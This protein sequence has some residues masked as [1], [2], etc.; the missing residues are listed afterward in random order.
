MNCICF[1][2]LFSLFLIVWGGFLIGMGA[3]FGWWGCSFLIGK[4]GELAAES[5]C[6]GLLGAGEGVGAVG[7]GEVHLLLVVVEG[8]AGGG[9]GGGVVVDALEGEGA[10]A[11]A[12]VGVGG[13]GV[14]PS[15]APGGGVA[16]VAVGDGE[17]AAV[18]EGEGAGDVTACA[19]G[20]V[21]A[22]VGAVDPAGGVFFFGAGGQ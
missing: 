5:G 11:V 19:F 21:V 14:F 4:G 1:V 16:V 7:G 6:K 9:V 15:V 10:G 18:F 3:V 12:V 13:D 20:V 2:L 22:P 17:G 8:E